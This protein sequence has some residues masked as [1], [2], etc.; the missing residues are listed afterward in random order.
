MTTIVIDEN[1]NEG[2]AFIELLRQ[3]KFAR[4]IDE[5]ED[6]WRMLSPAER[7]SIEEGLV[8]IEKGQTISHEQIK[9]VYER[10]L[11]KARPYILPLSEITTKISPN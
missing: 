6:W 11:H 5:A 8:D 10:W 1:T 2:K 7:Q 3:M 9:E 4:V